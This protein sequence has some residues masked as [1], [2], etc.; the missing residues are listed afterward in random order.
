M[1]LTT[2]NARGWYYFDEDMYTLRASESTTEIYDNV[3]CERCEF[4]RY[5][6]RSRI[7]KDTF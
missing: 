4:T 1:W 7:L 6:L 5:D 3:F 2:L